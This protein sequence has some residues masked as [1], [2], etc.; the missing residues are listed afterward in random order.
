M[1]PVSRHHNLV[2]ILAVITCSAT[3][4]LLLSIEL[5]NRNGK[6]SLKLFFISHEHTELRTVYHLVMN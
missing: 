1:A 5:S 2:T 4:S 6:Y 3:I